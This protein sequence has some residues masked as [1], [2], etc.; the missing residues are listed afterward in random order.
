M[1]RT[2]GTEIMRL[3]VAVIRSKCYVAVVLG[4]FVMGV[5]LA[6]TAIGQSTN[7]KRGAV[8]VRS[9]FKKKQEAYQAA[10]EDLAKG[11]PSLEKELLTADRNEILKRID[12][13]V[14]R[15][16]QFTTARVELYE[17]M[18]NTLGSRLKDLNPGTKV[19]PEEIRGTIQSGLKA[20]S[21][22]T[23]TLDRDI[24]GSKD[25]SMRLALMK[26]KDLLAAVQQNLIKQ[27]IALDKVKESGEKADAALRQVRES[28]QAIVTDLSGAEERATS[29][30][31]QY[32]RY[33]AELKSSVE[34]T[35]AKANP[36]VGL[37][38]WKTFPPTSA[39]CE[40]VSFEIQIGSKGAQFHGHL[41]A[42]FRVRADMARV[43]S[44][45][46]PPTLNPVLD[47]EGKAEAA[48]QMT[49]PFKSGA[50]SGD[51]VLTP[52]GE[53]LWVLVRVAGEELFNEALDRV[54][55]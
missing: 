7:D 29:I 3:M 41:V 10:Y 11:D 31:A 52:A 8:P 26:Q 14:G 9:D 6:P 24:E 45:R 32:N 47:F 36:L 19:D 51:V 27:Q 21:E 39:C 12:A 35:P 13:Q 43:L 46:P 34:K 5:L 40:V 37:W 48:G 22:E 42:G 38:R 50:Y 15:A 23:D 16:R 20:V 1:N 33:Y 54:R 49:F 53:Q 4:A 28:M 17:S 44:F 55:Q 18:R 30:G 25:P 2:P